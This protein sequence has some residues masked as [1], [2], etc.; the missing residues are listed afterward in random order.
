[1]FCASVF[2]SAEEKALQAQ[3][4]NMRIL[5]I[6][7]GLRNMGWGIIDS[8]GSRLSHVA[9]GICHSKGSDDLALRL[10]DLHQQLTDVINRYQPDLAAIEQTFVIKDAVAT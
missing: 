8:V 7:P 3:E 9:N 5:G 1:L 2:L 6:D 4:T 10:H